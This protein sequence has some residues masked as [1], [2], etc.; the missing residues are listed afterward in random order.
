MPIGIT[1]FP[2]PSLEISI[3]GKLQTHTQPAKSL[4]N[5][6]NYGNDCLLAQLSA[7]QGENRPI[8]QGGSGSILLP[9]ALL[10]TLTN[11]SKPKAAEKRRKKRAKRAENRFDTTS[12]T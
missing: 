12:N 1:A 4:R 11:I 7:I 2:N 9:K 5:L 10:A 3:F 6:F 8:A